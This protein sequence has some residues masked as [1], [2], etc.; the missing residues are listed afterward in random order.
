MVCRSSGSGNRRTEQ[1]R[2]CNGSDIGGPLSSVEKRPIILGVS[3]WSGRLNYRSAPSDSAISHGRVRPLE[4][5]QAQSGRTSLRANEARS[6]FV[7]GFGSGAYSAKRLKSTK[8]RFRFSQPQCGDDYVLAC[9]D[10][11]S[12]ER[13]LPLDLKEFANR[14]GDGQV[15]RYAASGRRAGPNCPH[16]TSSGRSLLARATAARPFRRSIH[17]RPAR[18]RRRPDG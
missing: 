3:A 12:N 14:Q 4:V 10:T 11:W 6:F 2:L 1:A 7:S 16:T 15:A 8:H 5:Y 9:D 18:W 13:R 17:T